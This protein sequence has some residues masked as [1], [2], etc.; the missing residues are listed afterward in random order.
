MATPGAQG[1]PPLASR[2]EA[3]AIWNEMQNPSF[4]KVSEA[5]GRL[6]KPVSRVTIGNWARRGAWKAAK[7]SPRPVTDGEAD[8]EGFAEIEKDRRELKKL[9]VEQLKVEQEKARLIYNVMMMRHGARKV[10]RLMQTPRDAATLMQAGTEAVSMVP[11]IPAEAPATDETKMI[12]VTPNN[13]IAAAILEF[14][15]KQGVAA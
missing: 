11:T 5:L 3:E 14:E 9:S 7:K 13:P 2:E 15:R 10:H 8:P 4:S 1:G 12:D 6:G